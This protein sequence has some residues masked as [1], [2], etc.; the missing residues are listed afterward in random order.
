MQKHNG[1]IHL[2][3][4]TTTVQ[5]VH[6]STWSHLHLLWEHNALSRCHCTELCWE[7]QPL[8]VAEH[9]A[10]SSTYTNSFQLHTWD[11]LL[12]TLMKLRLNLLQGDLAERFGVSQSIV[13]K[14]ISCWIDIMEENTRDYTPWLP[15]ETIQATM[16]QCFREH[17]PN[18]TCVIDCSETP[19][20]KLVIFINLYNVT[21]RYL[22]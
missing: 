18:T 4:I 7:K 2:S 13:C 5:T 3:L 14:V 22:L 17:F 16:P 19:L 12:M 8:S 11:H 15:R 20:Q 21:G 6:N 10:R 9:H 1:R